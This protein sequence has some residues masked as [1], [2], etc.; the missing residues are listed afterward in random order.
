MQYIP[1][2][3]LFYS[4]KDHYEEIY[5]QRYY[6]ESAHRFDFEIS[7]HPAF[8]LFTPELFTLM[9]QIL[10]LNSEIDKLASDLPL[11][12]LDQYNKKC[13]VDEIWITND[14][15][16]VVSTRNE[17][18]ETLEEVLH[19]T[20]K[21]RK[22]FDGLVQKYILLLRKTEIP[23]KKC[24][25]IRNLYDEFILDEIIEDDPKNLPDG[26]YF[27]EGHVTVRTQHGKVIHNGLYPETKIISMMEQSLDLLNDSSYNALIRMAI[28]HYLFAYIHPFYDGNGRMTRFISSY[29]LSKKL[30]ELTGF[31]LS[32]TI[33]KDIEKY[34][35]SFK[36]TNDVNNKGDLTPF[37]INFFEILLALVKDL[38]QSLEKR[39]SQMNHYFDLIAKYTD[40]NSKEAIFL[41]ALIINTLFGRKGFSVEEL[42]YVADLKTTKVREYVKK[43]RDLNVLKIKKEGHKHL[44]DINLDNF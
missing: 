26:L 34:Y 36:I 22:R 14:I 12:A 29:M 21:Q 18:N 35:K 25:D 17:I 40:I 43:Y 38:Y 9:E 23:L 13:L 31:R 33:K 6:S 4:N 8:F 20:E 19:P 28:F 3:K 16:G 7:G 39:S 44:Y 2:S 1:L 11:T 24:Q 42:E 10:E 41:E 15:E 5:R 32:Y 27:R 30:N 37:V